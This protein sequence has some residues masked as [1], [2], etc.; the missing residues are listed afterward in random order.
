VALRDAGV[1]VELRRR[2]R[3]HR[4]AAVGVHRELLAHDALLLAARGDELLRGRRR[5]TLGH[6]PADD[7]A[8]EDVEDDVK[9][10]VGAL[11]RPGS[12]VVSHDHTWFGAVAISCGFLY[13]GWRRCARRSRDLA[14][15]GEHAVH[16]P[17]RAQVFAVLEQLRVDLR[18]RH[19][20][21]R[22]A[23][24]SSAHGSRR[25]RDTAGGPPG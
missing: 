14:G 21:E 5:F 24:R 19:V 20:H 3:D 9:R 17:R 10:V 18:R 7:V 15:L 12:F 23:I 8:A 16:R 13:A 6:L 25:G 11:R 22:L 1:D 2:L 4:R